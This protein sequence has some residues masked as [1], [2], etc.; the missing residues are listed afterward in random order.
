QFA[1]R[2]DSSEWCRLVRASANCS[3]FKMAARSKIKTKD[4]REPRVEQARALP[5]WICLGLAVLGLV[6]FV[7]TFSFG[8]VTWDDPQYIT[9]N[10]QLRQGLTMSNVWW[11]LTTTYQFYWHPLTWLSYLVDYEWF[12]LNAG[13]YHAVNAVLHIACTIALFFVLREM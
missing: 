11:A 12:G 5:I 4:E 2:W 8:F 6:I 13:G 1:R 7:Q 10:L 3:R 9:E